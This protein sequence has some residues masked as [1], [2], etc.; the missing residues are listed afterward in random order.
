MQ[1]CLIEFSF[2]VVKAIKYKISKK[3]TEVTV[4]GEHVRSEM[5]KSVFPHFITHMATDILRSGLVSTRHIQQFSQSAFISVPH[6]T[7]L[8]KIPTLQ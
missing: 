3:I 6:I 7:D 5:N 4:L 2:S 1:S 8:F